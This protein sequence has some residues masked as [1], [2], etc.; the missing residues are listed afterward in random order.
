MSPRDKS[1]FT[2]LP[3]GKQVTLNMRKLLLL[4]LLIALTLSGCRYAVIEAGS[5][6]V[7]PMTETGER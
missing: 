3:K 1:E 7:A 6:V 4:L 5:V 2:F